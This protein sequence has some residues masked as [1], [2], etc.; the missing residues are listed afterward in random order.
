LSAAGESLWWQRPFIAGDALAFYLYKTF[1]PIDLCVD[2][3]RTPPWV[4]SHA[5]GYV[6]WAIP[7]GLL[8]VCY[9]YRERR[10]LTW[11]GALMFV[12][13]LLP[14]LGLVPFAYQAYST[15]ADRYAYLALIG[16][17]PHAR[18]RRRL[19]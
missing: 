16:G 18:R 14:T 5:W 19:R 17:R 2:Y 15:V 9:R 7:V 12:T 4:M 11:L 10:P 8:V 13:F 6:A 1:V 3:G